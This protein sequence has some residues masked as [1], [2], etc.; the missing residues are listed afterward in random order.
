MNTRAKPGVPQHDSGKPTID[1]ALVCHEV[2]GLD[3]G[4]DAAYVSVQELHH[5]RDGKIFAQMGEMCNLRALEIDSIMQMSVWVDEVSIG[6]LK[7]PASVQRRILAEIRLPL[8]HLMNEYSTCLYYTWVTLEM[9]GLH[10]SVSSLGFVTDDEN[11]ALDHAIAEGPKQFPHA[12]ACISV[13]QF[14]DIGPSGKI[15]CA[16]DAAADARAVWWLPLLRSQQQHIVLGAALHLTCERLQAKL[17]QG[18]GSPVKLAADSQQRPTISHAQAE[19]IGRLKAELQ[20]AHRQLQEREAQLESVAGDRIANQTSPL[21]LQEAQEQIHTQSRRLAD[22]EPRL[23]EAESREQQTA[24]RLRTALADLEEARERGEKYRAEA[25]ELSLDLDK[26]STE[27]NNKIE[28]ANKGIRTLKQ[29]REESTE[30]EAREQELKQK[31]SIAQTE[32]EEVKLRGEKLRIDNQNLQA[33]LDRVSNEANQKIAAANN[34]IRTLKQQRE[35]FD[36]KLAQLADD[37]ISLEAECDQLAEQKEAL[38]AIVDDLH[39]TCIAAGIDG[40]GRQSIENTLQ[41]MR[42]SLRN[43]PTNTAASATGT[44]SGNTG[45]NLRPSFQNGHDRFSFT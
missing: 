25:D 10:D 40:E 30:V 1:M 27:A 15:I 20:S 3:S 9:P 39:Q 33:E 31:L 8:R 34:C 13:C 18:H 6:E 29:R 21:A 19:E 16:S 45:E 12:K 24:Q 41:V 11:A 7:G 32:V 4:G 42:H 17:Q 28:Q 22:L 23:A 44:A 2:K 26:V 36:R 35:E 5:Q 43:A 38:L 37:K 14:S